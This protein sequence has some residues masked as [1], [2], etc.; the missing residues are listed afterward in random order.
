[1]LV[2]SLA[3]RVYNTLLGWGEPITNSE[4]LDYLEIEE[5]PVNRQRIA[6]ILSSLKNRSKVPIEAKSVTINGSKTRT[7]RILPTGG[8]PLKVKFN[9]VDQRLYDQRTAGGK[10]KVKKPASDND[11]LSEAPDKCD[12]Q[13]F[14]RLVESARQKEIAEECKKNEMVEPESKL[15]QYEELCYHYIRSQKGLFSSAQV[16]DY[17][18]LS[19][20]EGACLLTRVSKRYTDIKLT[21]Y[22]KAQ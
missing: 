12:D 18:E 1:M 17:Y 4:I 9:Q 5:T 8:I 2:K 3:E 20:E 22:A 21:V 19:E 11:R 6:V 7:Y 15:K 13:T 10:G 16:A 14:E